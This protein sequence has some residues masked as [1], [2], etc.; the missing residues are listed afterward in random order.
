MLSVTYQIYMKNVF[1]NQVILL[2]ICWIRF[3]VT[4]FGS[5][6]RPFAQFWVMDEW[7]K[8]ILFLFF[9]SQIHSVSVPNTVIYQIPWSGFEFS[10]P[11]RSRPWCRYVLCFFNLVYWKN[12]NN[13]SLDF[14]TFLI[15]LKMWKITLS[16]L[17]VLFLF[18]AVDH[19]QL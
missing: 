16:L 14:K 17:F 19:I 7:Q 9:L 1:I 10:S 4:K 12:V 6:F 8:I 2:I 3:L 11:L 13:I 18:Y 15:V 5:F